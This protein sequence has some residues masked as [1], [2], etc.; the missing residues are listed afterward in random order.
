MPMVFLTL[1][2]IIG[3]LQIDIVGVIPDAESVTTL[4]E[5]TLALL[6]F[7]DAS[8]LNL[9]K[10]AAD[11]QPPARLLLIGLPLTL[12][13][14]AIAAYFLFPGTLPAMALLIAAMLAPTDAALGLPIFT[15]KRVPLRVRRTLNVESGLNDGIAAPI[16]TLAVAWLASEEA[17]MI[18]ASMSEAV[19]SLLTAVA[20]G[21]LMGFVGGQF[22]RQAGRRGLSAG[23]ADRLAIMVLALLCYALSVAVGG[24]GF[25][26]AFVGGIVFGAASRNELVE[27]TEFTEDVGTLL[28]LLVW[29]LFGV[30]FV[31]PVI[32]G[33]PGQWS[34]NHVLYAV[35]SLTVIRM[36][37]VAIALAGTQFR[38]DSKVLMGWFGPRGLASVVFGLLGIATLEEA[39]LSIEPLAAVLSW[40]VMLSVF[41]HGL[42]AQPL[43]DLYNRRLERVP[44][45]EMDNSPEMVPV[46]EMVSRRRLLA[47][48]EAA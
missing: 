3:V 6:L 15:N 30:I 20:V 21:A 8:M 1:G 10:V 5:V 37:P 28:S 19:V 36:I 44:E 48:D 27:D 7:A 33:E 31:G 38:R 34:W 14:G 2:T 22:L 45:P 42:S 43:V 40:T 9:G 12:L 32:F 24:N 16:V 11:W 39:G 4:A 29:T 25:V 26:A 35:L 13:F 23:L 47:Q 46:P 18:G 17:I 41:A